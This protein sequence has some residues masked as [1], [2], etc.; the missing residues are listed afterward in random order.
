MNSI[1][2]DDKNEA[3]QHAENDCIANDPDDISDNIDGFV[4]DDTDDD[5]D[6]DDEDANGKCFPSTLM[7]TH[8]ASH[9][10]ST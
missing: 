5:A 1:F 9:H 6:D 3:I 10:K 8:T 2:C 7:H 4:D